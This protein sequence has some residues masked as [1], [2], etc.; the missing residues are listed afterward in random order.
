MRNEFL[1]LISKLTNGSAARRILFSKLMKYGDY[2]IGISYIQD[3]GWK[4]LTTGCNE[5]VINNVKAKQKI[6]FVHCDYAN[7][8]GYHPK[9]ER[10][11]NQFDKIVCVS[12]GCKNSFDSCFPNLSSKTVVSE[13]FIVDGIAHQ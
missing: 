6:A 9:V 7:Y 8:G 2:D 5:F 11:Y 1:V 10:I 12:N 13:N 4:K 3:V